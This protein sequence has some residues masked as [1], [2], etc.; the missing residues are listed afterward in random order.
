MVNLD[1]KLDLFYK[2]KMINLITWNTLYSNFYAYSDS[3][4]D[5][6]N[7]LQKEKL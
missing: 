6:P 5:L 4:N 1:I 3:P 2:L 7:S